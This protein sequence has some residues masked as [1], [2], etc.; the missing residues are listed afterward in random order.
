MDI[1]QLKD[2]LNKEILDI[3]RELPLFHES[4]NLGWKG[5]RKSAYQDVLKWLKD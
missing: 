5:G 3:D 4:A 2:K 1:E